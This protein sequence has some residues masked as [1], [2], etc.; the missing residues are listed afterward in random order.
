M[1]IFLAR[2]KY[3]SV[4]H[5]PTDCGSPAHLIDHQLAL[6]S[7]IK[8]RTVFTVDVSWVKMSRW[9]TVTW[10]MDVNLANDIIVY[11]NSF[12]VLEINTKQKL[13]G[14][15]NYINQIHCP[16]IIIMCNNFLKNLTFRYFKKYQCIF[17]YKSCDCSRLLCLCSVYWKYT[18]LIW[19]S[20]FV[21]LNSP[22]C[23]GQMKHMDT[24]KHCLTS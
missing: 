11:F 5:Q 6:L 16:Q 12:W 8:L 1:E 4:L 18:N 15:T 13:I 3:D 17:Q 19:L 21:T 10:L 9:P 23:S 24:H 22:E 20:C 7:A 14:N 2:Y